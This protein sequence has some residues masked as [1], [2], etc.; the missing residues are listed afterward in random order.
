MQRAWIVTSM[1]AVWF[2]VY[3]YVWSSPHRIIYDRYLWYKFRTLGILHSTSKQLSLP[4][5]AE[6][7]INCVCDPNAI[8]R[9]WLEQI[10]GFSRI[11]FEFFFLLTIQQSSAGAMHYSNDSTIQSNNE[12]NLYWHRDRLSLANTAAIS[13]AILPSSSEFYTT[14]VLT[15]VGICVGMRNVHLNSENR[16]C[17][18][19]RKIFHNIDEHNDQH[20]QH[21]QHHQ[22][23]QQQRPVPATPIAPIAPIA[24][25]PIA[26]PYGI[27]SNDD[28]N[29]YSRR[30][31][32]YHPSNFVEPSSQLSLQSPAPRPPMVAVGPA[33][34][35]VSITTLISS[36]PEPYRI[37]TSPSSPKAPHLP[38]KFSAPLSPSPLSSSSSP[39]PIL[40]SRSKKYRRHNYVAAPKKKWIQNYMQ[41][42]LYLVILIHF[43]HFFPHKNIER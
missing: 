42:K 10:K 16:Q 22:Q 28:S 43:I 7:T 2:C 29:L 5:K 38:P 1:L 21:P 11:D 27:V 12:W 25:A 4:R 13:G 40:S 39:S 8:N 41:S 24:A 3:I 20:Q 6:I 15:D 34:N 31:A 32:Y 30:I 26:N 9:L 23:Q 33:I 37:Y 14:A 36:Y 17:F 18:Y 35:A 19:P